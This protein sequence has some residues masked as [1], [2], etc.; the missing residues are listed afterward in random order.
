MKTLQLLAFKDVL[1]PLFYERLSYVHWPIE[2]SGLL[3][4]HNRP[5]ILK[6][7][8][9]NLNKQLYNMFS[10]ILFI[11]HDPYILAEG[12]PWIISTCPLKAEHLDWIC[13]SWYAVIHNWKPTEMPREF[14]LEWQ[15]ELVSHLPVL[16]DEK[17]LYK[18]VPALITHKFCMQSLNISIQNGYKGELSF[19]PLRSKHICEALSEPIKH[20]ETQDYFSYVYRFEFIT[21]GIENIPLLKVSVGIRRFYQHSDQDNLSILLKRRK[22][23]V[24]VSI[25]N[26]MLNNDKE[27]FVKLTIESTQTGIRWT[28]KSRGFLG[29]LMLEEKLKLVTIIR[30]LQKYSED[31]SVRVL[32]VYNESTFKVSGT[33]IERGIGLAEKEAL[34]KEFQQRFPHLKMIP[35]C[36]EV[37]IDDNNDLVPLHTPNGLKEITLEL[38]SNH[39]LTKVEEVLLKNGIVLE[40]MADTFYRLNSTPQVVLRIIERRPE[41]IKQD[42]Y[43]MDYCHRYKERCVQ[44]VIQELHTIADTEF[45]MILSLIEIEKC[46]GREKIDPKQVIRE[47]FA[48]TN[49]ISQFIESLT[50]KDIEKDR[51]LSAILDLLADRGFLKQNWNRINI[52]G[53]LVSLSI[54][55]IHQNQFLPIFS[56]INRKEILYKL[57]G[58]ENWRTFDHTI[59]SMDRNQSF[60]PQPSKR[61]DIGIHFK[62][63]VTDELIQIAQEAREKNEQVYFIADASIR[64]YWIEELQNGQIDINGLPK[65]DAVLQSF[66]NLK[67]IRINTLS[68]VPNYILN[69]KDE[70]NNTSGLFVDQQGIYYSTDLQASNAALLSQQRVLE[71]IILG[72]KREKRDDIARMIDY[73]CKTSMTLNRRTLM[74]YPMQMVKKIKNYIT[75]IGSCGLNDELDEDIMKIESKKSNTFNLINNSNI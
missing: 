72:A 36:Q 46:D 32:I 18:W 48:R 27:V 69:Q 22:G 9:E 1:D 41:R 75:D 25:R 45:E 61:N 55:K 64:D 59:L 51:I 67:G 35:A 70:S 2:W 43:H 23:T 65:I 56:K 52:P 63:F 74:P 28:K 20:E 8:L 44:H 14:P 58:N 4:E 7:K 17:T 13:R 11:Q 60:L 73:M 29:V 57:H 6:K 5:Y 54:E 39:M 3:L 16:H 26:P 37:K 15:S 10:D 47:G 71:I 42:P 34:L 31:K 62:Q 38:W 66:P 21:R 33:K 12:E 50:G 53:T 24:L 40:K 49:R 19:Y 30:N 68:D